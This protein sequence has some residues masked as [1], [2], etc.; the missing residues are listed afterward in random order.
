MSKVKKTN[1]FKIAP[2]CLMTWA[3]MGYIMPVQAAVIVDRNQGELPG[4]RANT[5]G[6]ITV[7]INSASPAGVSHNKYT[8]FDVT[9]QGVILNNSSANS[10]T[11]LA[12][13]VAGNSKLSG[14]QASLIIN[15]VTSNRVSRLNGQI[16]VAGKKADVIIANPGGVVCD[17]CGFINTGRSMLTSGT[18][19]MKNG[20]LTGINVQNGLVTITGQGMNDSSDY[21]SL[22]AAAVKIEGTLKAEHELQIMSGINSNVTISNNQLVGNGH[23]QLNP[24][25]GIDVKNLGGMYANKITLVTTDRNS[26]IRNAGIISATTD[27]NINS[28]GAIYNTR[29]IMADGNI[30]ASAKS[31]SNQAGK[32]T[33]EKDMDLYSEIGVDNSGSKLEAAG[34]LSINST[35]VNND[36]GFITADNVSIVSDRLNNTNSQKYVDNPK[37]SISEGGIHGVN[38]VAINTN[39]LLNNSYGW[40]TSDNDTVSLVSNSDLVLNYSRINA[41]KDIYVSSKTLDFPYVQKPD[42]IDAHLT[43]GNDINFNVGNLGK[44]DGTTV[45]DAGH[46]INFTS[47]D[48]ANT[49]TFLNYAKLSAANNINYNHGNFENYGVLDAGNSI[50]ITTTSLSNQNMITSFGDVN[51]NSDKAVYNGRNALVSSMKKLQITSPIVDNRGA[52]M[53]KQG[54]VIN[55]DRFTNLGYTSGSL[56]VNPAK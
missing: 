26:D 20:E 31:I 42:P 16:E 21:T 37:A 39:G 54:V 48:G 53:G 36:G 22:L 18:P 19:N 55:T 29:S 2:V 45:L 1:L 23:A 8:Q 47:L 46:D 14:G 56:T 34:G 49:G 12:G 7:N 35:L 44:F 10:T 24:S 30:T 38:G 17:G 27:L 41:K 15:E 51:I 4:I 3:V 25:V 40:V 43:A 5:N 13:S 11:Q 9:K 50:N 28:Q 52:L 33:S 6:S 32:I